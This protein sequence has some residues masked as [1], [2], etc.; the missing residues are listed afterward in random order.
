MCCAVKVLY[1][2]NIFP[3]WVTGIKCEAIGLRQAA[4]Q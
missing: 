3:L 1:D 4:V 2:N